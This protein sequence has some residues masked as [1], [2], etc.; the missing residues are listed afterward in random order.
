MSAWRF[1]VEL[2]HATGERLIVASLAVAVAG[3]LA[4]VLSRLLPQRA[5]RLRAALWWLVAVRGLLELAGAPGLPLLPAR[6]PAPP[7]AVSD[8]GTIVVTGLEP[9]EYLDAAAIPRTAPARA[10]TSRW[11]P[12]SRERPSWPP[13]ERSGGSDAAQAS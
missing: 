12:R 13:V 9:V 5:A 6:S 8:L 7:A 1:W 3:S 2:S 11:P 4:F 10:E